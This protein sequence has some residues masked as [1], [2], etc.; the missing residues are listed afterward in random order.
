MKAPAADTR[1]VKAITQD[2]NLETTFLL[3]EGSGVGVTLKKR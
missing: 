3:M 1:Y 2:P